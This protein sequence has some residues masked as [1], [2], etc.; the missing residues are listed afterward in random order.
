METK[1]RYEVISNLE[2][3][4]RDLI[5]ERNGLVTEKL[6]KEHELKLIERNKSDQLVAWDRKIEDSTLNLKNFEQSMTTRK[7]TI[8]ELIKSVDDSLDRFSKLQKV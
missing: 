1:S 4:K 2:Q 3:Q 7:E 6:E 8:Q 5:Q